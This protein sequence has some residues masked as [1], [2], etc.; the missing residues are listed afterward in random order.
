MNSE[1][2]YAL[3]Q[4]TLSLGRLGLWEAS[5]RD[6][7]EDDEDERFLK[8][9]STRVQRAKLDGTA[10]QKDL[11]VHLRRGS[12]ETHQ[13][14]F[15]EDEGPAPRKSPARGAG[16]APRAPDAPVA[17]A[18]PRSAPDA[19]REVLT[20]L[21]RW[22]EHA[23]A[24]PF[25]A[26]D[27]LRRLQVMV[28]RGGHTRTTLERAVFRL[29]NFFARG[30]GVTLTL[31]DGRDEK[32]FKFYIKDIP[33]LRGLELEWAKRGLLRRGAPWRFSLMELAD[34][35]LMTDARG[36][37]RLVRVTGRK[38]LHNTRLL[39]DQQLEPRQ[40]GRMDSEM[41]RKR[42]A[43]G[44]V[45]TVFFR[46]DTDA[47][48]KILY[49]GFRA[50]LFEFLI[51]AF[52]RSVRLNYDHL[53]LTSILEEDEQFA[54]RLFA[55]DRRFRYENMPGEQVK[56]GDGDGGASD[57]SSQFWRETYLTLRDQV[58]AEPYAGAGGA[59]GA[60]GAG[61]GAPHAER[62]LETTSRIHLSQF[63]F[64]G[65]FVYAGPKLGF[66]NFS[67]QG[68][69]PA[70][71]YFG[72]AVGTGPD[73]RP[74]YLA[75]MPRVRDPRARAA[76]EDGTM[77]L[78][79]ASTAG[80]PLLVSPYTGSLF[81][82]DTD[83]KP[84]LVEDGEF[85]RVVAFGADGRPIYI[86][87]ST[88]P[89][90]ELESNTGPMPAPA[91]VANEP[92]PAL[93]LSEETVYVFGETSPFFSFDDN[94]RPFFVAPEDVRELPR[95]PRDNSA[96]TAA[97]TKYG[98][99]V[100]MDPAGRPVFLANSR[101]HGDEQLR[102]E[103]LDNE[104]G[105]ANLVGINEVGEAIY[106][107]N[108]SSSVVKINTEGNPVFVRP[109]DL[110][111]T[112]AVGA[113]GEPIYISD[114]A[115]GDDALVGPDG[116]RIEKKEGQLRIPG[117]GENGHPLYVF[118]LPTPVF[119]MTPSGPA[120]LA[121]EHLAPMELSHFRSRELRSA[122]TFGFGDP[123]GKDAQGNFA[124]LAENS[125]HGLKNPAQELSDDAAN[126]Q[127]IGISPEGELLYL[128]EGSGSIIRIDADGNPAFVDASVYNTMVGIGL[129]S[130]P[131]YITTELYG[132]EQIEA[133]GTFVPTPE[134]PNCFVGAGPAG[135]P[136]YVFGLPGP[137][138]HMGKTGRPVFIDADE[139]QPL[140]NAA[141]TGIKRRVSDL[142]GAEVG[143]DS[144]G[145]PVFSASRTY[146]GLKK[147]PLEL[148]EAASNARL[149]G[150]TT[151][152]DAI[153]LTKGSGMLVKLLPSG[154][155]K[156]IGPADY[157]KFIGLGIDGT[158]IYLSENAAGLPKIM[159]NGTEMDVPA[160][161][162]RM[163]AAGP[164]GGPVFLF[165][166]PGRYF[167]LGT[168]G[169]PIFCPA[170]QPRQLVGQ[171]PPKH[172]RF[173]EAVAQDAQGR[174][175]YLAASGRHSKFMN[176][177]GKLKA[178]DIASGN[179]MLVGVGTNNDAIYMTRDAG[180]FVKL[181]KE[182]GPQII[183][184][185]EM[186]R[187]IATGVDGK[188]VY[189]SRSADG[190]PEILVNGQMVP[191]PSDVRCRLGSG[192]DGEP[193]YLHG[194]V[195]EYFSLD[196]RGLPIFLPPEEV[197]P[198]NELTQ[199]EEDEV[200]A[201]ARRDHVRNMMQNAGRQNPNAGK[202]PVGV[203]KD[204][205][206]VY[207][208]AAAR[209]ASQ[210]PPEDGGPVLKTEDSFDYYDFDYSEFVRPNVPVL[211]QFYQFKGSTK[212]FGGRRKADRGDTWWWN[213]HGTASD[214]PRL[215]P[216][217]PSHRHK[218]SDSWWFKRRGHTQ[219][220]ERKQAP[221]PPKREPG[222]L[223]ASVRE[224]F[225]RGGTPGAKQNLW[226]FF[227]AMG[228]SRKKLDE[229][230]E[231]PVRKPK[232]PIFADVPQEQEP[233]MQ[234]IGTDDFKSVRSAWEHRA[235]SER[236][237]RSKPQP[238]TRRATTAHESG[239]AISAEFRRASSYES[240]QEPENM[241]Q[242]EEMLR[243]ESVQMEEEEEGMS[244]E[245]FEA[246]I[247]SGISPSVR[248]VL[249]ENGIRDL[250][251]LQHM[252]LDTLGALPLLSADRQRLWNMAQRSRRM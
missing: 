33:G 139:V 230:E 26:M 64:P 38:L 180:L 241:A 169:T 95:V 16:D 209:Q 30:E 10:D 224:K 83:G 203:G 48:A 77:Q 92:K 27:E 72:R 145:D 81:Q 191:T 85:H 98:H 181:D 140:D 43:Q 25:D 115:E 7:D 207:G 2:R 238:R 168:G 58:L 234:Q 212:D 164:F 175:L 8:G 151:E 20:A 174:F 53:R 189:I 107:L 194:L 15:A 216:Q 217:K 214:Q 50:L 197:V 71:P 13:L 232:V 99:V 244:E 239:S 129:D 136:L 66:T 32:R 215:E 200:L 44:L 137:Y 128:T 165:G 86:S 14:R 154:E 114:L 73:G 100:G 153:Y 4:K 213:T 163:I 183:G 42:E 152:G 76:S 68:E 105:G 150:I 225:S 89:A 31:I 125:Q 187:M 46:A 96:F 176:Q 12:F 222:K 233:E 56:E 251:T 34:V 110:H 231:E 172:A 87:E 131:I 121:E 133:D 65:A 124:F 62:Q 122:R 144:N 19:R 90:G 63:P 185:E 248:S 205:Q 160:D 190:A 67:R 130:K 47:A 60:G 141:A 9:A 206:L 158:P 184:E 84:K 226:P 88:E 106:V 177:A 229:K 211:S 123:V 157:N 236:E 132:S 6:L 196:S 108:G 70:H 29:H 57:T 166:A 74:I 143:V 218:R 51:I 147:S 101:Q 82:L 3:E 220:E 93:T 138:F 178:L 193:R 112:I 247:R 210:A 250:E 135:E 91:P 186:H 17:A 1:E 148:E 246:C 201:R 170:D 179:A 252:S 192:P 223:S 104:K 102:A 156:E 204:G 208:T 36:Q 39:Y 120:F 75:A 243:Q 171:K 59:D 49:D 22:R 111:T 55:A 173:G 240:R 219:T 94:E 195:T 155:L 5:S 198:L 78:L 117:F 45:S 167:A 188:P 109:R 118:G 97:V 119:S 227:A 182:G 11:D 235:K 24:Q 162:S 146:H 127:L 103:F 54:D 80:E 199:Q 69:P 134:Q 61:G 41:D 126:A 149:V 28:W 161:S 23:R 52:P 18:A 37:Y 116:G 79:G 159:R 202:M 242:M 21:M 245:L 142:F 237:R 40:A 35:Q 221:A 228:V 249:E 113:D